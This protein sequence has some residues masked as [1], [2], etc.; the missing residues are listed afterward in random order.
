M[1]K[2][3]IEMML[4]NP[5]SKEKFLRSVLSQINKYGEHNFPTLPQQRLLRLWWESYEKKRIAEILGC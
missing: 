5:G 3:R 2:K 4:E 1:W